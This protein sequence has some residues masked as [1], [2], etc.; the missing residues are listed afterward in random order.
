MSNMNENEMDD[1]F[2]QTITLTL[3]NDDEV[4]CAVVAIFPVDNK[5]YMALMPLQEVGDIS[6]DEIFL[7]RYNPADDESEQVDLSVIEDDNEYDKVADA[8]DQLI[9]EYDDEEE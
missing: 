9:A 7:Y 2:D 5:Q 1:F 3:D 8:F 4:E 6:T